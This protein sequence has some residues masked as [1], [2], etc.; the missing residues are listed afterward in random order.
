M[1]NRQIKSELIKIQNQITD[2]HPSCWNCKST[3]LKH[4]AKYCGKCGENLFRNCLYCNES[5]TGIG[6]YCY[7]CGKKQTIY[8]HK[9]SKNFSL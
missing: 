5:I 6:D 3:G 8:L 4:D 2:L 7:H 9:L 1:G